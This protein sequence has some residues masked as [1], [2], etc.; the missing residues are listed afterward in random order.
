MQNSSIPGIMWA[1]R[2]RFRW[3]NCNVWVDKSALTCYTKISSDCD[4]A[5]HFVLDQCIPN[6]AEYKAGKETTQIWQASKKSS[7]LEIEF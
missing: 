4:N 1:K 7:F 3:V 2:K 5:A 6:S